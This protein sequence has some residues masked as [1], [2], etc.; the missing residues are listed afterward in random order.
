MT[1]FQVAVGIIACAVSLALLRLAVRVLTFDRVE[2]EKSRAR[3]G[4]LKDAL[5]GK[6]Q[7]RRSEV[8][9]GRVRAGIVYNQREDRIE[10]NGKLRNDVVD[11]I[12]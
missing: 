1:V 10:T 8:P 3:Y 2:Y 9:D 5:L 12:I 7:V 4:S 6:A 11:P